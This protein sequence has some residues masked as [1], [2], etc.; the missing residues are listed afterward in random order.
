MRLRNYPSLAITVFTVLAVFATNDDAQ[1]DVIICFPMDTNPGWSTQ[2]QWSFGVPLGGGSHCGDPTSGHTGTNVYGYNLSGDYAN[3]MPAYYL[4]TTALDCSGYENVTLRFWRWLGVQKEEYDQASVEVSR[5]GINWRPVWYNTGVDL[6]DG[7]WIECTYDIAGIAD[8]QSTVYIRWKMGPTN[9]SVIYPGWNIDDVC[10]L[11]DPINTLG[12]TP[13][14]GLLSSGFEG[15]P[16]SPSNKIYTL[17]N[18]GISSLDWTGSV[19]EPWLDVTPGGGTLGPG[20]SNIVMVYLTADVNTLPLGNYNDTVTFMNMTSG[21]SQTRDV[22]LEVIP[23]PAKIEV[24]DSIP[25]P[26][27][28]NMPFGDVIVD[29]SRTEQI[30]ISN[31]DPDYSLVVTDISLGVGGSYFEDFEDGLAQGWQSLVPSYWD[32]VSGEY[33]ARTSTTGVLMQSLYLGRLWQDRT[34]QVTVRR[35][36]DLDIVAGLFV[37]ASEDFDYPGGIGS[38]YGVGISGKKYYWVGKWISGSFVWL[39]DG[40]LYSSYLKYGE[41]S[42]VVTFNIVGSEIDVYFND[43]LAWSGT[44]NSI[45]KAGR[46]GLVCYSG[47]YSIANHYFDNVLVSK[48]IETS[49]TLSDEQQWYNEHPH[50]ASEPEIAPGKWEPPEYPGE[51]EVSPQILPIQ[52]TNLISDG[53]YLEDVPAFP[54]LIP[55]LGSITFDVIFNPK[56]AE[57]YEETLV[58]GSSDANNPEVEVQL[59]GRGILGLR[60]LEV[61]PDANSA[62]SGHPGGP[63]VP[64]NTS[65]QLTNIGPVTID[66]IVD[67]NVVWLGF[68]P[69]SG[70]LSPGESIT[71]IVAPNANADSLTEGDYYGR[72]NFVN[73]T[74]KMEQRRAVYLDVYTEPKIWASPYSFDVTIPQGSNDIQILTIG[75]TGSSGLEF[76]LSSYLSDF[77]PSMN[78]ELVSAVSEFQA[79]ENRIVLEYEFDEPAIVTDAH[80]EYDFVLIKDLKTYKRTGTPIIPVRTVTVLIPFGKEVLDTR[81]I[82]VKKYE[83]PGTYLLPPAQEPYPLNYNG[84]VV[85]TEPDAAIYSETTPWP[86]AYYEQVTS[87]SKRGYKLFVVN[88]FPLQYIPSIGQISYAGKLRLEIDLKDESASGVLR[89]S[90]TVEAKLL[91]KIDNPAVLKTYSEIDCTPEI[92][93]QPASLPPGGPYKYVIITNA[94][95]EGAPSPL[96]FQALRDAKI[97]HGMTATIVTTEWIYANYD[98]T[99]PSGGSDN[100]TRI[101]NFLIDAY[102]GWGTEYVLLGGTDTVIPARMFLVDSFAGEIDIMPVDM[103]YGCVEPAA[104]TF[105]SDA[106]GYYGEPCDGVGGGDVDLIAEIYVGRAAVKNFTELE[107][108]I[109]KT[110]DY[111]STNNIEYLSRISMLGEYIGFGGVAEYAK[112]AMEQIRIGG[113]YDGYFTYGFENHIQS[114]F[115]DFNTIDCIPGSPSFCWPLYDKDYV[116]PKS[117]LINLMNSGI[118][119]FNHLGHANY[120]YDM[121]LYASD[122]ASLT[123]TD[124]FFVYSQGCDPGGFDT[125]NCFAEVL[126]S[127]EHGAFATIMNARYGWGRFNSTDGPSQRFDRQFWDAIFGEGILEIGRANQ[128][129]KEDNLW[130]INGACIRWCYYELNLFGD[131]AQQI[132]FSK[133]HSSSGWVC[134]NPD[135]GTV[136]PGQTF[137]VNVIFDGNRLPGAYGGHIIITSNDPYVPEIIMSAT[138]TIEQIDYLAE[139]FDPKAPI[140]PNDPNCNDLAYHTLTLRPDGSSYKACI[141]EANDFPVDPNGGTIIPLGDDDY[142]AINLDGASINFF[143]TSYNTFYIGSNGYISFLS[144]DIRHFETLAD[145]FDLPR[146]SAL[147]DDLDPSAGDLISWKQLDDRVVITFENV[148]EYG[149]SNTNSFQIEM[150]FNGK[151]RITWLGID[152]YD[153]LVG[154]SDGCGLPLHFSESNLSEYESC[155]FMFDLNSDQEVDFLDYAML[156]ECWKDLYSLLETVLDEFQAI[157]YGGNN[158]TT[159]WSDDWQELGEFD[160]PDSGILQVVADGSMRLGYNNNEKHQPVMSLTRE[161]DL[162]SATSAI[163]TYDYAAEGKHGDCYVIVQVSGNGGSDWDTLAIYYYDSGSGSCS[164][165]ITPYISFDTQIRYEIISGNSVNMC[166]YIDNV[167]VE[168]DDPAQPWFPWCY[169][170]DFNRDFRVDLDDLVL[171]VEHWLE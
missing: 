14:K 52:S 67:S 20:D 107:S 34:V 8:G 111:D 139:L 96:N 35:T 3:N 49:Q 50:T 142:I 131:P 58:I 119:V 144:G 24:T 83:L 69:S 86:G 5:N 32:V 62:F 68:F 110:L 117:S 171:F 23:G 60:Y 152:A 168:F 129:S 6:C 103:Y 141:N 25:P 115:I 38:T 77:T 48:P 95:L 151:I 42:N 105:D 73:V 61:I 146:I 15:G 2:G 75:N 155:N 85:P 4:T 19:T 123:N 126:T 13:D 136:G 55:P 65:Y 161:V 102:Q 70:N 12:V 170:S 89:P 9:G 46:I 140:D 66:W 18:E 17:T 44:D 82:P 153:G 40:W 16:F 122:L 100:Q 137:D 63:F 21:F 149:S 91:A 51:S 157:S 79:N 108:F 135:V 104:C 11:G 98:G 54:I 118:H 94:A 90:A 41:T 160:G 130:D 101:R 163:L 76:S 28:L 159:N 124:Y 116:W 36:G 39:T 27:D 158:G 26:N 56:E 164:F 7:A 30:T 165:N 138:M 81:V 113:Q 31:T 53:F 72:L 22:T 78:Q 47:F 166:L 143:G 64:S 74:T 154:L 99:K 150:R 169:V 45:T 109:R 134:F 84:T 92:L 87:Q 147:F 93:D 59:S 29:L 167:Q 128:D 132:R 80:T 106:D 112:D 145:H 125:T 120:T 162:S 71:V 97:A 33:R 43:N 1:A 133:S 10:L 57:D 88:L 114:N 37:R 127:M 148:P 156:A 121:K